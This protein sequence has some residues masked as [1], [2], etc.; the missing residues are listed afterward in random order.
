MI[1]EGHAKEIHELVTSWGLTETD[2]YIVRGGSKTKLAKEV[3]PFTPQNDVEKAAKFYY[4][5]K[6]C[7]RGMIRYNANGQF[8]IP[9]GK[10]KTV[11]FDDILNDINLKK[12]ISLKLNGITI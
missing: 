2:Y 5:R 9:W 7:F 11:N 4:L 12:T 10:Y 1:G 3:I 8:N 6:T